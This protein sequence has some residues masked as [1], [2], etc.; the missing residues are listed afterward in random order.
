MDGSPRWQLCH[1]M[2]LVHVVPRRFRID[3]SVTVTGTQPL[4]Y[5]VTCITMPL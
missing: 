5:F 1:R 4:T 3:A 2:A